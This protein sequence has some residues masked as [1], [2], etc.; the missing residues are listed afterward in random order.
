M[1][2]IGPLPEP[3]DSIPVDL[4]AHWS[5]LDQTKAEFKKSGRSGVVIMC[6]PDPAYQEKLKA[7][8]AKFDTDWTWN[9]QKPFLVIEHETQAKE[10]FDK[11]IAAGLK[12]ELVLA[13]K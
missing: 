4:K 12:A 2:K 6:E 13:V 1:P 5:V 9:A 10:L 7:F 3:L 8:L 11:I